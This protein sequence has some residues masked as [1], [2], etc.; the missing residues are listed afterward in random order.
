MQKHR[1]SVSNK[2]GCISL[3]GIG[4]QTPNVQP[5]VSFLSVS[6]EFSCFTHV[7]TKTY[8]N[9]P[10]WSHKSYSL[11][12]D[13]TR[14]HMT[15][16]CAAENIVFPTL[17]LSSHFWGALQQKKACAHFVC[18]RRRTMIPIEKRVDRVC[19]PMNMLMM[20][21]M[22]LGTCSAR[23]RVALEYCSTARNTSN[24]VLT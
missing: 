24:Y 15:R 9:Q 7:E 21:L 8:T 20:L 11:F 13:T 4:F 3:S 2:H 12:A 10:K 16:V 19:S 18:V 1:Q 6:L 14:G 5:S 17:R 23:I 22:M